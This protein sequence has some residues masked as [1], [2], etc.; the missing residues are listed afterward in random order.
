MWREAYSLLHTGFPLLSAVPF[1]LTAL[2]RTVPG[3][4]HV[5]PPFY[6]L[7]A[8]AVFMPAVLL[9]TETTVLI[10]AQPKRTFTQE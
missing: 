5:V 6:G 7:S 3:K 9:G 10:H 1:V 4:K 8:H 2:P